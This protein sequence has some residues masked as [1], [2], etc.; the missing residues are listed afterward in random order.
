MFTIYKYLG[1]MLNEYLDYDYT[2]KHVA[3]AAHRALGLV[4]AKDKVHGGFGYDIFTKLYDSLVSS[5]IEYGAA[6]WG[7]KSYSCIEAVQRRACRYYL[8]LGKKAPNRAVEGDMGW[9]LAEERQWLCILR[10]WFR[11]CNMNVNALCSKI[12][13][14][15]IMKAS[16][17]INNWS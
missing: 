9:R 13:R 15:S 1:L 5:I 17:N 8:G 7:H 16:L 14:C 12:F 11:L 10:H 6:I 3:Q 4:I 2:A